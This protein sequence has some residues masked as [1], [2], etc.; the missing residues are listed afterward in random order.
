MSNSPEAPRRVPFDPA[1]AHRS[2]FE[3]LIDAR[4]EYGGGSVALVDGDERALSY[5]EMIRASFAL[6]S[7][8]KVGTRNGDCVGVMLPTGAA[9]ALAFFALSAF[10]RV[11]T[12]LNFTSGLAGI[13]SAICTAQVN[14]IV[15]ARR[16]VE[17]ACLQDVI[18]G[19]S[20]IEIECREAVKEVSA[21]LRSQARRN[22]KCWPAQCRMRAD[23]SIGDH[24]PG[25]QSRST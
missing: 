21:L 11:P 16:L 13:K 20:G 19:L 5:D 2:V 18:A 25:K 10:G 17:V 1:V 22:G 6:G 8:L 7:A 23:G 15:T 14:R 24:R 4:A 9:S 12:M 3:A